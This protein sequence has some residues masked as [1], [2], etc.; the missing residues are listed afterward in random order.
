MNNLQK[1]IKSVERPNFPFKPDTI[2]Y[3]KIGIRR[4]RWA[5]LLRNEKP[6]NIDELKSI[7]NYFNVSINK[8]IEIVK[9]N[10]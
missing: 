6:A 10:T 1:I 2:F 4:K 8:L 5:Q 9:N 3:K 7:S